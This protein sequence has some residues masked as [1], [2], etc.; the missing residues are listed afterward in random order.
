[1]NTVA[2]HL[3]THDSDLLLLPEMP[4]SDWLAA[5]RPGETHQEEWATSVQ[6]H[7]DGI[8]RLGSLGVDVVVSSRPTIDAAGSRRN[9]AFIWTR[10]HP[11]PAAIHQKYYLPDEPGYWEHSWYDRGPRRFDTARAGDALVG[12]AICTEMWFLEWARHYANDGVDILATPRATGRGSIDKWIAGGRVAAVCSGAYSLS[13]NLALPEGT[14]A[15]DCGGVGWV[16]DPE[17]EVLAT[18]SA[19][20]PCTTVEIDL[21]FARHSKSTYPRYVPE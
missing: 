5:E 4:F 16:I 7:L 18:T 2:E 13:S 15:A 12:V 8:E 17:G 19:E 1:M 6:R 21:A 9:E 14:S 10:Q 11:E 3:D 20:Q